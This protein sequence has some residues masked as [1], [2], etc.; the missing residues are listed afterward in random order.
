MAH[1]TQ[2]PTD[3]SAKHL[4]STRLG[5]GSDTY[6][7]DQY[8]C[9]PNEAKTSLVELCNNGIMGIIDEGYC[10]VVDGT[11]YRTKSCRDFNTGCPTEHY[12]S[13]NFYNNSACQKIDTQRQCYVMD[14]ICKD[15]MSGEDRVDPILINLAWCLV[16]VVFVIVVLIYL[17][18]YKRSRKSAKEME[19]LGGGD[20][21]SDTEMEKLGSGDVMSNTEEDETGL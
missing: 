2:C 20:V 1:V 11:R 21:M 5:C 16:A 19:K 10:L 6:G 13:S 4:A 14:P 17:C 9:A 18:I 3:A 7:N 15:Q 8:I 12:W